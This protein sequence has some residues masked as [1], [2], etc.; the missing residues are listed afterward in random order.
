M[1][2]PARLFQRLMAAWH[3]DAG[4]EAVELLGAEMAARVAASGGLACVGLVRADAVRRLFGLA[5]FLDTYGLTL[6]Q[7]YL[8][9]RAHAFVFVEVQAPKKCSEYDGARVIAR[10]LAREMKVAA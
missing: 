10:P 1:N 4:D 8:K 2:H 5:C 9:S 3:Q 6:R 7:R